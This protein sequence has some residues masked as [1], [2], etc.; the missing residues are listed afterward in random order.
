MSSS[1]FKIDALFPQFDCCAQRPNGAGFVP[2]EGLSGEKEGDTPKAK[3]YLQEGKL[4]REALHQESPTNHDVPYSG[5]DVKVDQNHSMQGYQSLGGPS[6][7]SR[8]L[9]DNVKVILINKAKRDLKLGVR[10]AARKDGSTEGVEVLEVHPDGPLAS[11][12]QTGDVVL[13]STLH[14]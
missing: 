14:V 9:K 2:T 10:L 3:Q 8:A 5:A 1:S 13:R 11:V 7:L 4:A 12:I 6:S